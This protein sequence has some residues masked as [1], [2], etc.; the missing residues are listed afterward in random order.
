MF[1]AS[2]LVGRMGERCCN[3]ILDH[4]RRLAF[5]IRSSTCRLETVK[6]L[7]FSHRYLHSS[8]NGVFVMPVS[9]VVFEKLHRKSD[10]E[11]KGHSFASL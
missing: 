8:S 11:E 2:T 5:Y 6:V 3:R 10:E 1:L 9:I 7:M 4:P